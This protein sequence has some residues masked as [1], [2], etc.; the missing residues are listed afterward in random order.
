[1][2]ETKKKFSHIREKVDFTGELA[3]MTLDMYY[4]KHVAK[5]RGAKKRVAQKHV[6][7]KHVDQRDVA[8]KR[9]FPSWKWR[10]QFKRTHYFRVNVKGMI[11]EIEKRIDNFRRNIGEL[12][13][14]IYRRI[15]TSIQQ[16]LVNQLKAKIA[17]R[18]TLVMMVDDDVLY[19]ED[20]ML[21]SL[22]D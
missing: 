20:Y 2:E 13:L 1:M 7:Q 15:Q 14:M 5:K 18:D 4:K 11:W 9:E 21:D 8:Q 19:D 3:T 22:W 12:K 10:R 17:Q 6:A 16:S